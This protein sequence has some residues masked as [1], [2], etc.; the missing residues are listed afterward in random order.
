MNP[1]YFDYNATTPLDADILNTMRLAM[2]RYWGNPSSLHAI[3][4]ETRYILDEARREI[5]ELWSC[6][7]SEIIFTSGGV[8]SVNLAIFGVAHMRR[9]SHRH[10]VTSAIEHHAVL[11]AIAYLESKHGFEVTILPVDAEGRVAPSDVAEAIRPDTA[12]VSIMAANNEV[13]T[14]QPVSEIGEIC[15]S[16][17]VLFHTDAIQWMGKEPTAS[18]ADFNAD[19]VS[20]CGH[21]FHGPKGAG[22]LYCRSPL[23]PDPILFG[24]AQENERRAG[25]ENLI[26]ILGL[27]EAIKRFTVDPVFPK[28][29]LRQGIQTLRAEVQRIDGARIWTPEDRCLANTLAF[30]V[31]RS[32]G[33]TLV[34]N[35]DLESICASSGAACSAGS[36]EPSHVIRALGGSGEQAN[37]LVRFSI[38]R[39]TT[40]A[41]IEHARSLLAPAILRSQGP[42]SRAK[43]M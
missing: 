13:G 20:V 35:L 39:E 9:E 34:A 31:D 24:G 37:A 2:E 22:V 15:R 4:R 29:R 23:L 25:T 43:R 17:G 26:A 21:K 12:L 38:G 8:E 33:V 18:I 1:I 27:T 28:T 36:I 40:D 14:I 42:V 7:P 11:N 6:R 3:G 30:T 19:L 16:A 41:D 5:A 10:L 32:D